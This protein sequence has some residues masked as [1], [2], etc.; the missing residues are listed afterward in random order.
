[1]TVVSVL[2]VT[3]MEVA[4]SPFIERIILSGSDEGI[5]LEIFSWATPLEVS[6]KKITSID[7]KLLIFLYIYLI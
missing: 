6:T 4:G 7:I 5:K 1:L 2:Q 3:A